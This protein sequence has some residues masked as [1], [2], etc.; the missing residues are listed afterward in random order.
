MLN[1]LYALVFIQLCYGKSFITLNSEKD[2]PHKGSTFNI[3]SH[4]DEYPLRKKREAKIE[5]NSNISNSKFD[6][7]GGTEPIITQGKIKCNQLICDVCRKFIQ[8]DP[9]KNALPIEEA[10]KYDY[11]LTTTSSF[12]SDSST[13]VELEKLVNVEKILDKWSD[14]SKERFKP[15]NES[16]LEVYVTSTDDVAQVA[17]VTEITCLD[18]DMQ[19]KDNHYV[20]CVYDHNLWIELIEDSDEYFNDYLINILY[21]LGISKEYSF[22]SKEDKC[23]YF[24]D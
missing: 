4:N 20:A 3:L 1:F 23:I 16:Q 13:F 22:P 9:I 6:Q 12:S 24:P 18:V 14:S 2:A 11:E 15:L 17:D 19:I 10:S 7:R 8:K 21:P 5:I